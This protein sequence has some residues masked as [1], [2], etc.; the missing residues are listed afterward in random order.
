MGELV[1]GSMN[2]KILQAEQ[3][4][5]IS[6][7]KTEAQVQAIIIPRDKALAGM[8]KEIRVNFNEEHVIRSVKLIDPSGDFTQI[9]MKN[10]KINQPIPAAVFEN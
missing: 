8:F 5:E 10:I 3:D 2:G 6:Y 7:H 4:F 1:A 9:N